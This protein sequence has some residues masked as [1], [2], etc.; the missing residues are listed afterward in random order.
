MKYQS[1]VLSAVCWLLQLDGTRS[2]LS[3]HRHDV[4]NIQPPSLPTYI[5]SHT[6]LF[7]GRGVARDYSWNEE[8]FEIEVHLQ[9]PANTRAK[10]LMFKATSTSVELKLLHPNNT[11]TLLLD[12]FRKLRGRV[13]LDGTYWV[14]GDPED[15]HQGSEDSYRTVTVTIEKLIQTPKDDFEIVEYDWKGI[16]LEDEA[17]GI[18]NRDYDKAETLDVKKYAASMGVDLDNINMSMVDKEMFTSG[19]N[20]TQSTMNEL[21]KSG[22][23]K[24][25]TQQ[26]DGTQYRVNDEGEPERVPSMQEAMGE[27]VAIPLIDTGSP[28]HSAVPVQRDPETNQT[29]VQQTRNFTRTAFAHDAAILREQQKD[30]LMANPKTAAD[31]IDTL[32]VVKLKEILKSQGLKTSGSKQ[33][34][35]E[36]LRAQVNSLLQ[37]RQSSD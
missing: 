25:V 30:K 32:T 11:E 6:R 28:W 26:A 23:A 17:D 1:T 20:L 19:L 22:Y 12:P 27:R 2:F 9:V 16:Y 14:I 37:G 36:R 24:E 35:K 31:P 15:R 13:N 33:E 4:S 18:S 29:Y 34:L 8:A 7:S 5:N 10:D 3:P 21:T